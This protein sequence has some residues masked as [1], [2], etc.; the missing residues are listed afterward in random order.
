MNVQQHKKLTDDIWEIAKRLRGPYRPP[1]YRLVMLPMVVLRRLDCVLEDSTDR[2][3]AEYN[4]L[5]SGP[6]DLFGGS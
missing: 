6:I 4:R 2:V 1:Q 3:H 5:G